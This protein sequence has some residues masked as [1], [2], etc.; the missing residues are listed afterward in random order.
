[1][2]GVCWHHVKSQLC[3]KRRVCGLRRLA[4]VMQQRLAHNH[5]GQSWC[6]QAGILALKAGPP[7]SNC[8]KSNLRT[9]HLHLTELD[10]KQTCMQ[11]CSVI[12]EQ[13]T[14]YTS[15]LL[16]HACSGCILHTKLTYDCSHN[17]LRN[18]HVACMVTRKHRDISRH[19]TVDPAQ[20]DAVKGHPNQHM[21]WSTAVCNQV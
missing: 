6:T 17:V 18:V 4:Q 12:S 10:V 13:L 15:V 3:Q 14:V 16:N 19:S 11:D 5:L 7:M 20:K 8:V 1:M 9:R 2:Q 21:F